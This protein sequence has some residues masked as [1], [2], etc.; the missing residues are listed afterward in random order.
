VGRGVITKICA[1]EAILAGLQGRGGAFGAILAQGK[2][3][4]AIPVN[5]VVG[6]AGSPAGSTEAASIW[7]IGAAESG[8]WGCYENSGRRGCTLRHRPNVWQRG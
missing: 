8:R 5:E 7:P 2:R 1:K 3:A 4:V 6:V